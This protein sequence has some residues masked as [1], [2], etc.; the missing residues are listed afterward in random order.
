MALCLHVKTCLPEKVVSVLVPWG[1]VR[2]GGIVVHG[3]SLWLLAGL[4]DITA[5]RWIGSQVLSVSPASTSQGTL[6]PR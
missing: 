6:G 1:G 5:N 4:E 2:M 3:P